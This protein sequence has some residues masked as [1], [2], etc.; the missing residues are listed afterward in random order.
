MV[1]APSQARQPALQV[2]RV[3]APLFSQPLEISDVFSTITGATEGKAIALIS[4]ARRRLVVFVSP[5]LSIKMA[6]AIAARLD[7]VP[8]LSL[9][10]I[11][12]NDP[13]VYR[14]SD[15][16]SLV[17]SLLRDT[18]AKSNFRLRKQPGVCTGSIVADDDIMIWD[19]QT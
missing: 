13:D 8:K 10:L 2:S 16:D 15:H 6:K 4:Q 5:T 12:D 17:I 18:A 14:S 9:T 3:S 1:W 7:D 11:I 19:P